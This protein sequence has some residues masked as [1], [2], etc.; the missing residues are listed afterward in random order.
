MSE[1]PRF[2]EGYEAIFGKKENKAKG[3]GRNNGT[4]SAR[5]SAS[6]TAPKKTSGKAASSTAK[7]G[8]ARSNAKNSRS[9]SA[10]KSGKK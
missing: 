4:T 5:P 1:D 10:R 9:A 8:T 3:S 2:A 6:S 7:S